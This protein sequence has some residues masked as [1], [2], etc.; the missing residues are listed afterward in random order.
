MPKVRRAI[1]NTFKNAY[2]I[3]T[4]AIKLKQ[5]KSELDVKLKNDF[6]T[7]I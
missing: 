3:Q 6:P 2:E 5:M 4:F 1:T 7:K